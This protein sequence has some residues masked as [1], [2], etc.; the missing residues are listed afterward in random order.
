[1]EDKVPLSRTFQYVFL[2]AVLESDARLLPYISELAPDHFSAPG[3]TSLWS[4]LLEYFRAEGAAP[5]WGVLR[6]RVYATVKD[7]DERR[8]YYR[9][10]RKC[11]KKLKEREVKY[12][13]DHIRDYVGLQRLAVAFRDSLPHFERGNLAGV[14]GLL[15]PALSQGVSDGRLGVSYF[16]TVRDRVK[17]RAKVPRTVVR[18]LISPLDSCLRN[19]GLRRGETGAVLASTGTGKTRFLVHVAKAA[20]LQKLKVAYY[21]L[22]L[23]EE[24]IAEILDATFSGVPQI[25]LPDYGDVVIRQVERFGRQYGDCILIKYFPRYHFASH[26][27]ETHIQQLISHDHKPD[28]VVV[29]FMNY[30]VLKDKSDSN[31]RRY[32]ELGSVTAD[33]I[34]LCQKHDMVGWTAFQAGRGASEDE[35][36]GVDRFAESYAAAMECTLVI[37]INRKPEEKQRERARLFLAKYTHGADGIV[38]QVQTNFRKGSFYSRP[39]GV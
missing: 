33:F 2:T 27:L 14:R 31:D 23:P 8:F 22:Q 16:G 4:H 10:L 12:V 7:P 21:T 36:I 9:V 1:V 26:Q 11:K 15:E 34:N 13:Y 5:T 35:L 6:E 25:E 20:A 38:I 39:K 28:V 3:V 18:T 29:D 24:D 32:Y 19:R 17:D 37:S 30:M